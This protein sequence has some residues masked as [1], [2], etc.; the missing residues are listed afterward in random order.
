[1]SFDAFLPLIIILSSLIPGTIIFM[2]PE[3]RHGWRTLLNMLGASIKML[4]IGIMIWGIFNGHVYETRLPLLPGLDLVLDA[5]KMS[6]LIAALSGLL[7]FVTTIYAIGYL[8]DSQQPRSRFFGFF[9]LCVSSTMGIAL[10]GNLMTFLLFY[11]ML[12]IST[13]PLVVHRGTN[14]SMRAR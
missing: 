11:E 5:D 6:V 14:K 7:W 4:L 2:L 13:Y 1:M 12:T 10:A 3:A 9:S 8:E